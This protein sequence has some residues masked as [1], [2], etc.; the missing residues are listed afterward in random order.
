MKSWQEEHSKAEADVD[1]YITN[2]LNAF[3]LIKRTTVDYESIITRYENE[4][5]K[6]TASIKTFRP[7]PSDLTGAVEGLLRLQP[8]YKLKSKD[9]AKGIIDGQKTRQELSAHDL[10]TIGIEAKKF[11][12][13]DFF[14]KEYFSLALEKIQENTDNSEDLDEKYLIFEL[15]ELHRKSYHYDVAL[16]LLDNALKRFPDEKT[17][18][19][20]QADLLRLKSQYPDRKPIK[21]NP[22]ISKFKKTGEYRVW[23][24]MILF[25]NV[26]RGETA[27]SPQELSKL[28]CRY[29]S[30][31]AFTK[32][33][34]FKV[35]EANLDPYIAVFVDIIS[36]SETKTIVSISKANLFRATVALHPE[37]DSYG[38]VNE[39]RLAKI[40]GLIDSSHEVVA[41]LTR[42]VGV[43]FYLYQLV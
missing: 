42:R 18:I 36:D 3:L 7:Q 6:F 32:I 28:F 33:A 2:P 41:R 25:A 1:K 9:L 35:E 37:V 38:I 19:E 8:F 24:E 14:T 21:S 13:K 30:T 11:S 26:C 10:L 34:P 4:F 17:F 43:S 12:G 22:Y 16:S 5:D 29:V 40:T 39:Y 31:S 20:A 15:L 27:Q 23:K